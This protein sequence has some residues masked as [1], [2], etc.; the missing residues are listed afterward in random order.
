ME[1]CRRLFSDHVSRFLPESSIDS[2]DLN[3]E[4]IK[5]AI[6]ALRACQITL[7]AEILKLLPDPEVL[8]TATLEQRNGQ[9]L[10]ADQKLEELNAELRELREQALD[11]IDFCSSDAAPSLHRIIS[12]IA[13]KKRFELGVATVK[14]AAIAYGAKILSPETLLKILHGGAGA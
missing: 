13:H 10:A 6:R 8:K 12:D 4:A 5:Y 3:P 14:D 1:E 7:T 2:G 9:I 11:A